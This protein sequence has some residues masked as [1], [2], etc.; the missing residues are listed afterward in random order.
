MRKQ[1]SEKLNI[2]LEDK[3]LL[4]EQASI[5]K[6]WSKH[7][8]ASTKNDRILEHAYTLRE[9][10][11]FIKK[12]FESATG[13]DIEDY[14]NHK[15]AYTES[16]TGERLTHL[17]KHSLTI[18]RFRIIHFYRFI[19][20]HTTLK[21]D[22][23]L[24]YPTP[25]IKKKLE[26][27]EEQLCETRVKALL[28]NEIIDTFRKEDRELNRH[29]LRA[30][31]SHLLLGEANLKILND[32]HKYK[33]T[34][35]KVES[36]MGFVG[37]LYLL[38]RFGLF[39]ESK[40][41]NEATREDVQNFLDKIYESA[42]LKKIKNGVFDTTNKIKVNTSYKANLLDFYRFVYGYFGEE[43]P[44]QYP[45]VVSWLYQ[46]KKKGHDKVAKEII[47]D[48]E[49]KAMIE[50]STEQRD[51]ALISLMADS[52]GRV[53]EI[54][55][56]NLKDLKIIPPVNG[57]IHSI[58]TVILRGK[59]GERTNQLFY[60]VP[61]LRLWLL[62][63][64][65]RDNPSAPLFIATKEA[66]YGL[67]LSAVGINN[68]LQRAAR[69]AGVKRHIHA[70]LFRHTNLTKMAKILSESELKI[71]AGWGEGSKMATVY[72][73]LTEK[74]VAAK[75]LRGYGV[76][77]GDGLEEMKSVLDKKICPNMI[78][79][80]ENPSEAKFCLICGYPLTL[81]T[82]INLQRIKEKEGKLQSEIMQKG[83][84]GI[85]LSNA[86]DIREAMWQVLKSDNKLLEKLKEIFED[87]KRLDDT[88]GKVSILDNKE[89]IIEG[90]QNGNKK[91][92]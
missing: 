11:L 48:T 1:A 7:L 23:E 21:I 46:K 41:Y 87:S 6:L 65:L 15:I 86:T 25:K 67:R 10:A 34:S 4:P 2:L 24:A 43:K 27:S 81:D 88:N 64:P 80:Y 42:K 28:N 50:K 44:R 77:I 57:Q 78:C 60:S 61:H 83:L 90:K 75:I 69:R 52:S 3:R 71:H 8:K 36:Y 79:N 92:N 76:D 72:V 39:L 66:R 20:K 31:Y 26:Q 51:K 16:I 91:Y 37:K 63:H 85:D 47:P 53:S 33:I 17:N 82:A 54:I 40:T 58:A 45:E 13:A 68:V 49:I 29:Q 56:I 38:K 74:D 59:T 22:Q 62:N 19:L 84:G 32:Y 70:H 73:H 55:S 9:L 5:I 12:P 35:G 30:K 14:I 89:N 18:Y